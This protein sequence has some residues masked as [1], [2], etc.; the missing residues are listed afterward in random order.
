MQAT[1]GCRS[2]WLFFLC[3]MYVFYFDVTRDDRHLQ[4]R[5]IRGHPAAYGGSG[6]GADGLGW[7]AWAVVLGALCPGLNDRDLSLARMSN[8]AL[9]SGRGIHESRS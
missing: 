9:G 1:G 7:W 3:A 5:G 4:K 8:C 6:W 2:P